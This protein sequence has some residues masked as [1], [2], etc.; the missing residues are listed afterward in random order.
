MSAGGTREAI[1]PVRF[2]G[3]RSTGR[4]GVAIAEA[5]LARGARVTLVAANL[6]VAPP[7][8]ADVVQVESTADLRD[9]PASPD[10]RRRR[11]RR[12]RRPRHGRRRR[13][14][15]G[16]PSAPTT[17]SSAAATSRS[18]S[19]RPRT[20]SPRSRRI[21]RGHG[22]EGEVTYEPVSPAPVLVGFAAETGSLE[23]AAASSRR[24]GVDLLVANDVAEPGSGF[25]TDTNRVTILDADGGRED[26]PL[27]TKREVADEL[28]DRVSPRAGRPR[29]RDAQTDRDHER[30]DRHA[31]AA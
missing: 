12:L 22:Q 14:T 23:R 18:S 1:D 7:A 30:L 10:P 20:S 19:S 9:R 8:G 26:L 15:S 5:A 21:V 16:P 13:P 29:R 4:M 6:E 3:N 31:R 17:S 28:L 25:G 2:I 24:K 27:L 11:R